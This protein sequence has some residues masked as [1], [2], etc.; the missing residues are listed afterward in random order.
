MPADHTVRV[1][2]DNRPEVLLKGG[3]LDN[4]GAYFSGYRVYKLADWRGRETLLPT[5]N[6]WE[7]VA[8]FGNDLDE[9]GG[10]ARHRARH[11]A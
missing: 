9:R 3:Q 10:A 8:S 5:I 11:D 1:E 2:W 4:S 6:N 7:L